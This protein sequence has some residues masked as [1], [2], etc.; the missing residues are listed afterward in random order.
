MELSTAAFS[1]TLEEATG[2]V[3]ELVLSF[4]ERDRSVSLFDVKAKRMFLKRITPPEPVSLANVYPGATVVVFGR[5]IK[6]TGTADAKTQRL[7]ATTRGSTLIL[8][9]PEAYAQMGQVLDLLYR[10][11][12][13]GSG[14]SVGRVRAVRF[15]EAAAEAFSKLSA[16]AS[17]ASP[18]PSSLTRD[19][20]LAIEVTGDDVIAK[21]HELVGPADPA[22]AREAAPASLRAVF[23]TSRDKNAVHTSADIDVAAAEIAYLFER[24]YA[25]TAACTHCSAVVIRPHA[26]EAK[27]AGKVID[28]FLAQ[29]LEVSAVRSAA[30]TREDAADYLEPYRTVVPEFERWVKELSSAPSILLEVRGEGVVERVRDLCGP[31]DPI[32]AREL[33]P[34]TLR[35]LYGVDAARN[36]I[37]CTDID[38]DGPLECRFLFSVVA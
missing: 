9:K 13:G 7:F 3:R 33:R 32:I 23:G 4:Y 20:S 24:S 21:V 28:A 19:N 29:G 10:A 25:Y 31:Y 17:S 34:G 36:A 37:F 16:G 26:V 12:A 5:S 18:N 11:Q 30:M 2:H 35:A 15:N 1:A 14:L 27:V 22:D 38:R 6:V 8:I